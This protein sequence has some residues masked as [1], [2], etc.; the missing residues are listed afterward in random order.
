MAK[1]CPRF[2]TMSGTGDILSDS[3][4]RWFALVAKPRHEKAVASALRAKGLE[5]FLPLYDLRQRWGDRNAVVSLPLFPG[6]LFGRFHFSD[7]SLALSTPGLF[8]I[9]RIGRELAPVPDHEI[10][11]LQRVAT[12]GLA[13]QPYADLIV[14]EA[15]QMERGPLAGLVGTLVEIKKSMRLVLSVNLLNRSVLIEIDQA[16]V[17]SVGR[18]GPFRE[19]AASPSA[20]EQIC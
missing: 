14:G 10:W 20:F 17:R 3:Q 16:W 12:S 1:P 2:E 8:D 19:S 5:S 15:V 4:A 18:K 11:A 13:A 9:V 6:Y 7:K